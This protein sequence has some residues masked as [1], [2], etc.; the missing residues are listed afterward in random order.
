MA[1]LTWGSDEAARLAAIRDD[2]ARVSTATAC[3]MLFGLGW[4]NTYMQ[5]LA[6]LQTLGTGRRLVGRARTCR[7][8]MRRGPV[9]QPNPAARRTSAEIVLIEALEPGDVFCVDALGVPTAGIIGDILTTRIKAR[10]AVAAVI[11]GAVRD[12]PYVKEVGLPVYAAAAHPA[13]SNRDVIAIDYDLPVNM[14]GVQVLPGDI[15]LADDEGV[16]ALP[17]DLAE[18]IASHGPA[19]EHL[20]EWIRGRIAAGGS[21][22]DY[23]PPS[24]EKLAEY[25]RE[26]GRSDE[27]AS[28]KAK[29]V[30]YP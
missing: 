27:W 7:Y 21:V 8:L 2:L 20:E 11:N 1:G 19:K 18:Q 24:A 30:V 5:G 17:L 16:L 14:A 25:E 22:H 28:W 4:R 23:Y 13:A 10:G 3:H 9:A 6:P 12:T 29:C 26:A 15:I